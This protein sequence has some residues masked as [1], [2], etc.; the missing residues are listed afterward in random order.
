MSRLIVQDC[1]DPKKRAY[2]RF[3]SRARIRADSGFFLYRAGLAR[4]KLVS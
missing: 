2:K 1:S 3:F 4:G